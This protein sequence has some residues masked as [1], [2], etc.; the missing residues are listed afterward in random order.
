MVYFYSDHAH[1]QVTRRSVSVVLS[2]VRSMPISCNSKR[3]GTIKISSNSA[4]FCAGRVASEEAV[5]LRYMLR[6]LGVPVKGATELCGDNLGMII[7]CTNQGSE[8]KKKHG[9]ISYHKFQE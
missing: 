7:S 9:A 6:S 5:A 8:L 2:F 1:D 3:H 4:E